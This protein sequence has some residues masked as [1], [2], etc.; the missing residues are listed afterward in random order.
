MGKRNNRQLNKIYS[1]PLPITLT[2]QHY[3]IT[4]PTL[5]PHNPISWIWFMIRYCQIN[6][7]YPVPESQTFEVHWENGI[8]KVVDEESMMKLWQM[9]FFGKGVLSRSEPTWKE[10]VLARKKENVEAKDVAME[11]I[12]KMRREER[13]LFKSSRAQL[14]EL[15]LKDRQGII[16]AEE[17]EQLKALSETVQVLR[18]KGRVSGRSKSSIVERD[19]DGEDTDS[20]EEEDWE[21]LAQLEYLQLQLVETFFLKFALNVI[22][23]P[24]IASTFDLFKTCCYQYDNNQSIQPNNKFIIDYVV[25]HHFRSLGWC[26]RSGIKFGTD[27]LLYKR[28]PPFTHAEYCVLVMKPDEQEYDWFQMAAKARVIGTVKKIFV[29]TYV[30]CPSPEEFKELVSQ[31]EK[32]DTGLAI[33]DLLQQYKVSEILYRRWAPSRT[34]D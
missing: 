15:E 29:L 14:Q 17:V 28:G 4:L 13:K 16:T 18:K 34:R 26:V 27:F 3:G 22:N 32:D 30:G 7:F 5:Y 9:G 33:G 2:S 1:R 10:R 20:E 11:D 12:T 21:E 6:V 19:S 8:F 25:Y 31:C 24:G 23:I